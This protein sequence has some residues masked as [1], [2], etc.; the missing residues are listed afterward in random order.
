MNPPRSA[1]ADRRI[2]PAYD[3]PVMANRTRACK[4]NEQT[5][6]SQPRAAEAERTA[7][8]SSRGKEGLREPAA[9]PALIDQA[10]IS[11]V[12]LSSSWTAGA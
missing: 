6:V 4:G 1:L 12:H 11:A 8:R 2:L 9:M 3:W 5:D 10:A 7:D